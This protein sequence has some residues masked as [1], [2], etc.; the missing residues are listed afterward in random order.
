MRTAIFVSFA[1]VLSACAAPGTR[2]ADMSVAGHQRAAQASQPPI[3]V[4]HRQAGEQLQAREDRACAGLTLEERA[5]GF[6]GS[7]TVIGVEPLYNDDLAPY[8]VGAE[9]ELRADRGANRPWLERVIACHLAEA[10]SAGHDLEAVPEC[11][12]APKGVKADLRQVPGGYVISV[13]TK[14]LDAAKEV[15]RRAQHLA[16]RSRHARTF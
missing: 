12:F 1:F 7:A 10:A 11:P 8:L 16:V 6:F 15:W 3:A 9:I 14:D 5:P 4:Q 13:R 2:P